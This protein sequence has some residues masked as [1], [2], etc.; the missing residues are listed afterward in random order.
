MSVCLP[1]TQTFNSIL[2]NPSYLSSSP[3][4]RPFHHFM[5]QR[6]AISSQRPRQNTRS[7]LCQFLLL[8]SSISIS[9]QNLD[10]QWTPSAS[11]HL[12]PLVVPMRIDH[13]IAIY[14]PLLYSGS[15]P[16][17]CHSSLLPISVASCMLLYIH[18]LHLAYPSV[19]SVKLDMSFVTSLLL[20]PLLVLI[21]MQSNLYSFT[22]WADLKYPLYL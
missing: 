6:M 11:L 14:N 10:S 8:F 19:R 16:P 4:L 2:L 15:T 18:W 13:Y 12:T 20:L 3:N 1:S 22:L 9:P 7:H 21:F 17:M 5:S